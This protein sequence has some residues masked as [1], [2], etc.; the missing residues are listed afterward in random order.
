MES[1]GAKEE[2]GDSLL[3]ILIVDLRGARLFFLGFGFGTWLL[4]FIGSPLE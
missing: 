2:R 3:L 4:S 1:S